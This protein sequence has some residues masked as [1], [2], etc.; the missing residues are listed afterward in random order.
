MFHCL[1]WHTLKLFVITYVLFAAANI[2]WFCYLMK[3]FYK[4]HLA[5]V[6]HIPEMGMFSTHHMLILLAWAL[7]AGGFVTFVIA[8]THGSYLCALYK[9][10]MYGLIIG[11]SHQILNYV[12]I[13]HWPLEVVY[14]TIAWKVAVF[15]IL[16]V[17]MEYIAVLL[18]F[19][20]AHSCH[21]QE[22]K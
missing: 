3:D 5:A 6:G 17:L 2:A 12:M 9:G 16:A 11:G 7:V 13:S 22:G 4:E 19:E 10:A 18:D 21:C 20:H 8:H 15:A 1:H 14:Y